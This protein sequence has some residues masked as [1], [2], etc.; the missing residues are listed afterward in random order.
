MSLLIKG[1]NLITP[2]GIL[3]SQEIKS[4]GDKLVKIGGTGETADKVIDADGLYVSPGFID[5]HTHGAGGA[6]YMDA[7]ADAYYTAGHA[8]GQHGVTTVIP[9][10]LSATNDE[11][12]ET[13][14]IFEKIKGVPYDGADMPGLHLEGPYFAPTMIGAQDP[15][16]VR[17]PDPRE[18]MQAF[19]RSHLIIRW[20][21]APELPG[22]LELGRQLSSRGILAAIAHSAATL[23]QTNEAFDCG[24]RLVTH[25]YACTSSSYSNRAAGIRGLGINEASYLLDDM[26]VE[27]IGDGIHVIPEMLYM[28]YKIKGPNR[29]ILCTD[30]MRAAGTTVEKSILGSIKNG[31]EVYFAEGVA[32]IAGT[33][34]TAASIAT[35]QTM[36]KVAVQEAK[37]PLYDAIRMLSSTPAYIHNLHDRGQLIIGKRADM[38]LFDSNMDI[39]AVIVGG[40][41]LRND[42]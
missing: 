39:K 26:F 35:G 18:Y 16:Y 4:A 19:D 10:T 41:I 15:A 2:R 27:C 1:A 3:S 6:D 31:R 24:Y 13:F 30:S 12:M 38:T 7:T 9:T 40:R 14:D 34:I 21:N 37:I 28:T 23:S 20:S 5:T 11:L 8:V 32:K 22:A 36:L 25:L 33:N 42:I 17:N 29:M